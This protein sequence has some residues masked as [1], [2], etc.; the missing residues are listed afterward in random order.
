MQ[1]FPSCLRLVLMGLL[2]ASVTCA[3]PRPVPRRDQGQF[4]DRVQA[5]RLDTSAVRRIRCSLI[6]KDIL[7]VPIYF[8][9]DLRLPAQKTEDPGHPLDP[10]AAFCPADQ[11][12]ESITQR[13]ISDRSLDS[14]TPW[15]LA[16]ILKKLAV[17]ERRIRQAVARMLRSAAPQTRYVGLLLV[18]DLEVG[19]LE[20]DLE[21]L[22]LDTALTS[23][24]LDCANDVIPLCLRLDQLSEL[25]PS[26][27]LQGQAC[28]EKFIQEFLAQEKARSGSP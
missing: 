17:D 3:Q 11:V 19:G 16:P 14:T 2:L 15:Q 5:L 12:F 26:L 22:V 7:A 28:R 27:P 13:L 25:Y 21:K 8:L 20:T 23:S 6:A 9:W 4:R 10:Y 24:S 18:Q 1:A